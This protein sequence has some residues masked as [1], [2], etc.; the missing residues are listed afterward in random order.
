MKKLLFLAV[1]FPLFCHSAFA[2]DSVT[3][4]QAIPLNED[5]EISGSVKTECHLGENLSQYVVENAQKRG[6]AVTRMADLSSSTPG[7][8]ITMEITS[9]VSDGNAFIGHHKSM[10]VKGSL[11]QDGKL[12]GNFKARRV[13][14]GGAFGQFK[15]NCGVLDRVN[16][17]LGEDIAEWMVT[18]GMNGLL[19]DLK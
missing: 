18:P 3:I 1:I 12:V 13:S 8:V 17:E 5:A 11:Y 2:A 19:G 15:G 14:M 4:Q 9:A 7:R 6:M 10:S 16:K